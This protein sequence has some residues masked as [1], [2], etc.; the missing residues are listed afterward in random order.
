MKNVKEK[1]LGYNTINKQYYMDW[2]N[3]QN[4][5]V[6]CECKNENGKLIVR[7]CYRL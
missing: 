4:H 5:D 1:G 2:K 6:C 3:K 7:L